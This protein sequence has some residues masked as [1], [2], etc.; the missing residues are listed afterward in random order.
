MRKAS[1]VVVMAAVGLLLSS[2]RPRAQ[3]EGDP[4]QLARMNAIN[5][6][7]RAAGLNL[8]VERI[9][10]F[11]IGGG[12]PSNRIHQ[13]GLRWVANDPRRLADG[14]RITYL[15]DQSDGATA[16]GLS[17]AETE[18]AIDRAFTTWQNERAFDNVDLVKRADSGADPDIFD[19]FFGLAGSA[20]PSWP[21]SSTPA[22]TRARSSRRPAGPEAVAGFLRSR[23]RSSSPMTTAGRPTSTVTTISTPR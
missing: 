6:Q 10:F 4:A 5:Q 21:T 9:D 11:T 20:I 7:L 18:A 2:A 16:S 19:A 15:V 13:T 23:C 17:T 14:A 3:S 12:R 22:G 8:A 1:L